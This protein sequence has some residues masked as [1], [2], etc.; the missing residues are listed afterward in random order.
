MKGEGGNMKAA[1][2]RDLSPFEAQLE[3]SLKHI[4]GSDLEYSTVSDL[5]P[6][7]LN[8]AKYLLI[9]RELTQENTRY[10]YFLDHLH[11]SPSRCIS[12]W[13]WTQLP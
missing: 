9:L 2:H 10:C 1:K 11:P 7:V 8:F 5:F 3:D 13:C 12:R 4:P 6:Y